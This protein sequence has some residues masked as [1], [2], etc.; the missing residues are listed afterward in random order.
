MALVRRRWRGAM[1]HFAPFAALRGK[2]GTPQ[3]WAAVCK[4]QGHV[5]AK[6]VSPLE[7]PFIPPGIIRDETPRYCIHD[8]SPIIIQC[9]KC[10][11]KIPC[12][13]QD[14]AWEA[15]SFCWNCGQ[16]HSW[17]TREERVQKLYSLI[18]HEDL[19]EADRLTVVEQLALL[20]A[21]EDEVPDDRRLHAGEKIRQLAPK[22]WEAGLPVLQGLLTAKLKRDLGLS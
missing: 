9:E 8:G 2:L 1:H 4:Q 18:D 7:T 21:P 17:A 5:A 13:L 14:G 22:A 15:A 12:M 16:P 6:W 11:N 19:D 20:A 3:R 10:N